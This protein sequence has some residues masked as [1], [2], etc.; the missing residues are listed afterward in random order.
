MS[1][2]WAERRAADHRRWWLVALDM[3]SFGPKFIEAVIET[4]FACN[5][6][7]LVIRGGRA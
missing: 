4:A 3:R 2:A 5:G 6:V 1:A 7:R